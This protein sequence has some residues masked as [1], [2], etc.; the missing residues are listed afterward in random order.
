MADSVDIVS[1]FQETLRLLHFLRLFAGY[2]TCW[3]TERHEIRTTRDPE[4]LK[5]ALRRPTTEDEPLLNGLGFDLD[6]N[7]DA[8]LNDIMPLPALDVIRIASDDEGNRGEAV[9]AFVGQAMPE[10]GW[11]R[12]GWGRGW[13]RPQVPFDDDE[14]EEAISDSEDSGYGSMSERE[15]EEDDQPFLPPIPFLGAPP[16]FF[17]RPEEDSAPSTSG[18]G[19]SVK[20]TR[21]EDGAGPSTKRTR[22]EDFGDVATFRRYWRTDE[23]S[24]ED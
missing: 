13:W 23:D 1:L 10:G 16:P 4:T 3:G 8:A 12:G 5:E 9:I 24:D 19:S 15:D 22:E 14:G 20:R 7:C 6:Y 21:E 2:K 18:L 11:G 17:P